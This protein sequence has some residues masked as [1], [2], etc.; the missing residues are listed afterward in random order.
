MCPLVD[1]RPRC[2]G[3][4]ALLRMSRRPLWAP[5]VH[6]EDLVRDPLKR[7]PEIADPAG[8]SALRVWFC[9]Y[10]SMASLSAFENL[11]TLVVAGYPDA[12][13]A[14]LATLTRLE[15]LRVMDFPH[16]TD[17]SPLAGLTSLRTL[18]LASPPSWDSSGRVIEVESLEPLAALPHLA[19]LELFGVRPAQRSLAPLETATA[20]K[21]VRVSKYPKEEVNRYL[22]ATGL[23]DSF[24]PELPSRDGTN[25]RFCRGW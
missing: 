17:L 15:Y 19:H 21:T 25:A 3:W 6:I 5:P 9:K 14:A 7:F 24:A 20:L 10:R 12:D 13:F 11:R 23:S 2:C 1:E 22:P 18:R 8:V 16:I 4:F